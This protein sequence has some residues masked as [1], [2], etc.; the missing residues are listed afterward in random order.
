MPHYAAPRAISHSSGATV[1][2]TAAAGDPLWANGEG[3]GKCYLLTAPA[4]GKMI[5]KINNQCPGSSNP[6]CRGNHFDVAVPGFDYGPASQSNVCQTAPQNCD[7]SVNSGVCANGAIDACDCS[8]VGSDPLLQEGCRLFQALPWGDNP[9][10]QFEETSCPSSADVFATNFTSNVARGNL[11]ASAAARRT[12]ENKEYDQCGGKDWTG[13]TCCPDGL[14]CAK[15]SDYYSQC[16]RTPAPPPPPTPQFQ[17]PDGDAHFPKSECG[18]KMC[19]DGQVVERTGWCCS[20]KLPLFPAGNPTAHLS[21]G[22][23]VGPEGTAYLPACET[24]APGK[25]FCDYSTGLCDD[26][27]FSPSACREPVGVQCY[28]HSC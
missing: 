27:H 13:A 18:S 6:T 12:C 17:C 8:S 21:S 23:A 7:P 3:C 16:S 19:C 10:V 26:D 24:N 11:R 4:G 22:T 20:D 14:V 15:E 25:P 1:F 5:V 2:A 28:D 9:D